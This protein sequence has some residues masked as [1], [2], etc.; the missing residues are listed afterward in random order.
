MAGFLFRKDHRMSLTPPPSA[1]PAAP[2]AP[3]DAPSRANPSTFRAL[4]DAFVAWQ[5]TFRDSLADLRTWLADYI[6][7]AGTNVTELDALQADVTEKANTATTKASDASDSADAAS[8]S[9]SAAAASRTAIDNR[10]YPGTYAADPTTR[11]DGSAIQEGDEYT[12]STVN[13]RKVYAG[14]VWI[15]PEINAG[16]LA[17]SSGSSLVGFIQS[18]SGSAERD[19]E[20][21]MREILSVKDKGAVGDGAANDTAAFTAA[22]TQSPGGKYLIPPGTYLVDVSPDV[23]EDA[24]VAPYAN[25]YLKIDGVTYDISG[26]FGSGWKQDTST[27]T[28]LLWTHARTGASI[29]RWSD[30]ASSSD[31][32]RVWLPWDVRRDSHSYISAPATNGGRSDMLWRRSDAN[33]DPRGNRFQFDFDES[34]DSF[35]LLAATSASGA[36]SYDAAWAVTAGLA[37]ALVFPSIPT[38]H[39]QGWKLQTRAGGALKLYYYPSAAAKATF[40]DETSGNVLGETTRSY[41]KRGGIALDTLYDTP[42]GI[43]APRQWGG[44]FSDLIGADGTLP[45][46]KNLWSTTGAT[47]NQVIGTLRVAAAASGGS[48]YYRESRFVFDGATVTL[49][50]IVNTLPAQIT[51]T[52]ALSGTDLQFQTSYSGGLG[53]GATVTAMAQWCGAGR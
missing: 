3:G 51:A 49:T 16:A 24:F 19:A 32:N 45:A 1:P 29:V 44:V 27:K 47:R 4:A 36:P 25:T 7:W 22:R 21:K 38:M 5:A 18:G 40:K 23:W 11:P 46:T 14:G 42:S 35:S 26:C 34:L 50:D 39:N 17:A 33:A 10:L 15:V 53:T 28:Y 52:I 2:D 8:D 37:P 13:L 31:S 9:A 6:T 30:G 41:D 48:V 20:S 43:T 12:N